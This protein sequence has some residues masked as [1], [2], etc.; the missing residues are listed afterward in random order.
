MHFEYDWRE[1][2]KQATIDYL[3]LFLVTS[4]RAS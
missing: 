2:F 1:P 3:F 4:G